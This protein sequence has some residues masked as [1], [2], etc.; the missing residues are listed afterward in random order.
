MLEQQI[1]YTFRSALTRLHTDVLLCNFFPSLIVSQ[2][3]N[4]DYPL[5]NK[6]TY[7]LLS[8]K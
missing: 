6:Q 8:I 7:N 5:K 4:L 3:N 1:L 2:L